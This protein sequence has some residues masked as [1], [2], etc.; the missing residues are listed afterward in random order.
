MTRV[1]FALAL[2]AGCVAAASDSDSIAAVKKAEAAIRKAQV[3]GDTEAMA[4]LLTDDFIRTPPSTPAT[5]KAEWIAQLDSGRLKYLSF[6][7]Q[8]AK[9][10]VFGDTVL[11]NSVAKIRA[12]TGN[13]DADLMLRLLSVW[14]K[15][16]GEWRE[17]AVQG[18]PVP[19]K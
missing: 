8:D 13:G 4:R 9:Y 14:V 6:E 18:N 12:R 17:A 3:E 19:G 2:A 7:V 10:R 15:Q 5:T 11:V 1:L 16:N